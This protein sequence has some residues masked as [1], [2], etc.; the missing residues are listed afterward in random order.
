MK[1]IGQVTN[2]NDA[3]TFQAYLSSI[4]I[5]A[6]VDPVVDESAAGHD[7]WVYEIDKLAVARSEFHQFVVATDLSSYRIAAQ[8]YRE[9]CLEAAFRKQQAAKRVSR[10]TLGPFI[11]QL[12]VTVFLVLACAAM[13]IASELQ[14]GNLDWSR[15]LTFSNA[16][17]S[18]TFSAV[19]NGQP[20]WLYHTNAPELEDGEFW[21]L[22]TPVLLHKSLP[23]VFFNLLWLL[24]FGS[25]IEYH[26]GSWRLAGLVVVIAVFSNVAQ[27]TQTGANFVGISGVDAGLFGYLFVTGRLSPQ[28]DLG[29]DRKTAIVMF[30][31]LGLCLTPVIPDA[32]NWSHMVGLATG[33]AIAAIEFA[34]ATRPL[35]LRSL[36][37]FQSRGSET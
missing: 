8:T 33:A 31:Y 5:E 30:A 13:F 9:K 24:Q 1:S 29:T 21:R 3:D 6:I 34:H 26:K 14:I 7:I 10:Q 16:S 35:A 32:A 36:L 15:D 4:G 27:F 22:V 25:A 37:S 20:H 18:E 19:A 28:D 12:P 17:Q 11:D 2:R 23:H